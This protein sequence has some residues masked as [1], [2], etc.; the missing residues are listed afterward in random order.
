MAQKKNYQRGDG[1]FTLRDLRSAEQSALGNPLIAAKKIHAAMLN[2]KV[3]CT[4]A[5]AWLQE[6]FEALKSAP[7][8]LLEW[9]T[10]V[11]VM[12]PVR[13]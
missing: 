7:R 8:E 4:E 11:T 6:N 12:K 10:S 9:I 2:G 5:I 13:G 3:I 1:V